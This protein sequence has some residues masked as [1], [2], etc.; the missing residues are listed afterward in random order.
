MEFQLTI[1]SAKFRATNAAWNQ[2][3]LNDPWSVGYVSTLIEMES[4]STKEDWE[5][6][7]YKSGEKRN[8]LLKNV[9]VNVF[10]VLENDKDIRK[11]K[12]TARNFDWKTRSINTSYGRTKEQLLEKG[13]L[14]RDL[15]KNNGVALSENEAFECVRFRV[16]CETWNGIIIRERNT[17]HKLSALFPTTEFRKVSGEMDHQFAVDYELYYHGKL[18]AAIQIKPTSYNGTAAYILKA[19]RANNIKNELYFEK[20]GAK[21]IDVLSDTKGNIQNAEAIEKLKICIV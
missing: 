17:V 11:S 18:A 21:V 1:D 6:F 16:I 14:L 12:A 10:Q 4:Y 8:E 20:F 15:M 13:K 7:Y 9:D 2:L 5:D 3:M 19:K